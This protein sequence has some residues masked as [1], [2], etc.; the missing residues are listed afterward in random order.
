MAIDSL[1]GLGIEFSTICNLRCMWCSLDRWKPKAFL[2]LDLF[3]KVL[4][5]VANNELPCLNYVNLFN[6][7]ESLLHPQFPEAMKILADKKPQIKPPTFLV[8]NGTVLKGENVECLFR[9]KPVDWVRISLD[10]G[11]PEMFEQ[12]RQGAKWEQVAAN[13]RAFASHPER[14]KQGIILSFICMLPRGMPPDYTLFHPEYNALLS[15]GDNVE[16]RYAHTWD[17]TIGE[18]D[19]ITSSPHAKQP[20]L[21]CTFL[22]HQCVV[23]ASGEVNACCADLNGRNIIGNAWTQSLAEIWTGPERERKLKLWQEGRANEIAACEKCEGYY[24]I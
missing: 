16:F 24:G 11:S 4:T 6:G 23:L 14:K 19:G 7:G 5:Q 22:S 10:G 13:V 15:L 2:P 12:I 18:V 8:S 9:G 1:T 20:H 17:G 21:V 3:D